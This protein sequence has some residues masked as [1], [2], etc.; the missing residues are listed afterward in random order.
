M[1]LFHFTSIW[2]NEEQ[3]QK[4]KKPRK[5]NVVILFPGSSEYFPSFL[6]TSQKFPCFSEFPFS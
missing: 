6:G 5:L 1:E 3:H 4:E 2:R